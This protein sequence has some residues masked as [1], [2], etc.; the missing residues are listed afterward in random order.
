M[1]DRQAAPVEARQTTASEE[2]RPQASGD[3]TDRKP[4]ADQ[5]SQPGAVR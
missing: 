4:D 2:E 1:P 5:S 3:S